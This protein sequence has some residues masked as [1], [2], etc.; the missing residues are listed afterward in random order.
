MAFPSTLSTFARP[1]ATD[2]LNNPSH[3][4]LHNTVSSAL[5]QVEAVIGVDG[6]SSAVGTLMYDVR[7]PA[8]PG[9]GHV[10]G[11]AYGGTGQTSYT[12]GD[13]LVATSASVIT[14]LAVGLDTQVLKVNSSTASGI[15]WANSSTSKVFA[16]VLS[17]TMGSNNVLETSIFSVPI[18]GSTLGINNAVRATVYFDRYGTTNNA[19]SM[20]VR[21]NYGNNTVAS[22]LVQGMETIADDRGMK[23][24][25]VFTLYGNGA[26]NS[27]FGN[28]LMVAGKVAGN[29]SSMLS[30]Y[31]FGFGTSSVG[32]GAQ[33]T[34]GMTHKFSTADPS[35]GLRVQ[36]ITVEQIV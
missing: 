10:Q 11:A 19:T 35:N 29:S 26:A 16:S 30:N 14:K 22:M 1:S 21:A 9:G 12:K 36:G 3:S 24:S 6:I 2:R 28:I 25:F 32:S 33:N 18:S 8:S 7:S 20:L 13:I 23:G 31:A 27:Q 4:D 5:G 17:S 15:N 34:F